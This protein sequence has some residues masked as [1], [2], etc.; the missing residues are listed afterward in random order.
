MS[1]DDPPIGD[2][3]PDRGPLFEPSVGD[4]LAREDRKQPIPGGEPECP[5]C[6]T[7]LVR[8][9]EK[10]PAPHGGGSPFR[11]RLTCPGPDCGAWTVY[12]W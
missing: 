10:H 5:R 9:V 1:S 8:H 7:K 6:G 2:T 12:D 4:V 11:V 3:A